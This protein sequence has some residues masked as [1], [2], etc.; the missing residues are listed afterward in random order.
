MGEGFAPP[1]IEGLGAGAAARPAP[2]SAAPADLP[3]V[4]GRTL[5]ALRESTRAERV[6]AWGRDES[7]ALRVLAAHVEGA[8]LAPPSEEAFAALGALTE[9]TDLGATGSP[10]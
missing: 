6:A 7:G 8:N 4:L 2:E 1:G 10:V 9:A 5:A 3:A